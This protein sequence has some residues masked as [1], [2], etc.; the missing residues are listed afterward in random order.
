M[1]QGPYLTRLAGGK[2]GHARGYQLVGVPYSQS[3]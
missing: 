2:L 3:R 1:K